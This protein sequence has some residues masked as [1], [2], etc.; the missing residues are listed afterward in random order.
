MA[1]RYPERRSGCAL[2]YRRHG[3]HRVSCRSK[4]AVELLI[5]II[6][7][8]AGKVSSEARARLPNVPFTEIVRMRNR[9]VHHYFKVD[10]D[11]VWDVVITDLQPLLQAVEEYLMAPGQ[12]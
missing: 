2:L 11:L 4:D 3:S 1:R 10:L 5:I 12:P 8:A 6:G 9:L 7:E